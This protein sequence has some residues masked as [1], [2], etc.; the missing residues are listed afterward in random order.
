MRNSF[1]LMQTSTVL[2]YFSHLTQFNTSTSIIIA[3]T[4][5]L[6]VLITSTVILFII[7]DSTSSYLLVKYD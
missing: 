4:N 1:V 7:V 2:S 6:L 5:A 3:S